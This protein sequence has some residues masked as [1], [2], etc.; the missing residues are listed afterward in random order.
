MGLKGIFPA[1]PVS[2]RFSS[3]FFEPLLPLKRSRKLQHH[4]T[5]NVHSQ[6]IHFSGINFHMQ[7]QFRNFPELFV[8]TPDLPFL[9]FFENGKENH[10]KNKD[11]FSLANP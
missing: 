2:F 6:L 11:F 3:L 10:Q 1:G 8:Y 5:G 9:A 7:L 4:S